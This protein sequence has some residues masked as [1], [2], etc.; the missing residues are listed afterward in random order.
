MR[1]PIFDIPYLGVMYWVEVEGCQRMARKM[2]GN[3]AF[4]EKEILGWKVDTLG[5]IFQKQKEVVFAPRVRYWEGEEPPTEEERKAGVWKDEKRL[6]YP[7]DPGWMTDQE[8][9]SEFL[10]TGRTVW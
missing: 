8:K 2:S 10:A 5:D 1:A 3:F 4:L 9:I 6:W 7:V